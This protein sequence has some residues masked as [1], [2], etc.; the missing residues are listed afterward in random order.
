MN[1]GKSRTWGRMRIAGAALL[2]Y[3]ISPLAS[4]A[5]VTATITWINPT[6][7]CTVGVT[8]CDNKPLPQTGPGALTAIKIYISPASIPLTSTMA[9][10][11]VLP[12]PGNPVPTQYVYTGA[13][14]STIFVR[15]KACNM[16]TATATTPAKELC[17]PFSNEASKQ[18]PMLDAVPN[19]PTGVTIS[20]SLT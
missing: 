13:E 10:S 8:P 16:T 1:A 3:C 20:I 2:F 15:A 18:L 17:S 19:A 4:A 14:G 11:F 7:G 12:P 6:T 9:P 5:N